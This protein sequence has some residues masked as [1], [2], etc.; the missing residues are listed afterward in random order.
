MN[1]AAV[2][3]PAVSEWLTANRTVGMPAS[4][5]PIMGR[6]STRATHSA[7]R[8]GNGTPTVASATK[9][10]TPAMREVSRLPAAYPIT[11]WFIS[12]ATRA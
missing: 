7:H 8:N 2:T 12:C 5:P 1:T 4:A 10:T 11:D 6:K 9:I 3:M